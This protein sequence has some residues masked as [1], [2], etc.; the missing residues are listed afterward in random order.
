MP[1]LGKGCIISKLIRTF[2][3]EGDK[4]ATIPWIIAKF[5][6]WTFSE[7]VKFSFIK[8]V[9]NKKAEFPL[10]LSQMYS[11]TLTQR[12]NGATIKQK[13]LR[14]DD[15]R[16]QVYVKYP[17]ILMLKY[18]GDWVYISPAEY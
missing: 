4:Y 9:K 2:K 1:E 7:K 16:M 14:K 15:H 18:P 17:A 13:E 3:V 11:A 12:H 10:I 8:A 5:S 6:D